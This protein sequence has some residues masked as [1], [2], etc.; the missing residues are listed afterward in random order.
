MRISST[1]PAWM[2]LLRHLWV[3]GVHS[4]IKT[5]YKRGAIFPCVYSHGQVTFYLVDPWVWHW[6]GEGILPLLPSVDNNRSSG[7]AALSLSL[8]QFSWKQDECHHPSSLP[9]TPSAKGKAGMLPWGFLFLSLFPT[10]PA[11]VVY[12]DHFTPYARSMGA[13]WQNFLHGKLIICT[14]P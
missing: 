10:S 3:G 4:M 1:K 12:N 9:S 5:T 2:S 13:A 7:I 14:H 6:V 8:P 11:T